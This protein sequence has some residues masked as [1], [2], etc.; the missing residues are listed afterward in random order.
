[1]SQRAFVYVHDSVEENTE[2]FADGWCRNLTN[3]MVHTFKIN[4]SYGGNAAAQNFPIP[5]SLDEFFP[6]EDVANLAMMA[7]EESIYNGTF[8]NDKELF[9]KYFAHESNGREVFRKCFGIFW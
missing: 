7:Y 5:N 8:G 9:K 3:I 4:I 1:M 2:Q 6:T